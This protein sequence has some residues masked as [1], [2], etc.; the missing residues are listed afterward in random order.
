MKRI[1][2]IWKTR[3][4]IYTWI[5]RWYF[6]FIVYIYPVLGVTALFVT[7]L[8]NAVTFWVTVTERR[9]FFPEVTSNVTALLFWGN[10]GKIAVT[11]YPLLKSKE[12]FKFLQNEIDLWT[13]LYHGPFQLTGNVSE[14][15]SR[16][17]TLFSK[18]P[19][20]KEFC[21][22]NFLLY[23]LDHIS[24]Q[25]RRSTSGKCCVNSTFSI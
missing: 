6:T 10:D 13:F 3:N 14:A 18:I 5:I 8:R 21:Y 16:A 22:T 11:R 17:E 7:A 2:F 1:N 9:Y 24:G 20:P 4:I 15:E 19:W 23:K 12:K 25:F